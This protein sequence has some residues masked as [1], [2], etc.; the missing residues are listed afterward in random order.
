MRPAFNLCKGKLR[1]DKI[2]RI[3]YLVRDLSDI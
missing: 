1:G 3:I 2:Y